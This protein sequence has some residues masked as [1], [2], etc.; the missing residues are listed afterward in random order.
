MLMLLQP[1]RTS[2][3][4]PTKGPSSRSVHCTTDRL[5]DRCLKANSQT[6][7]HAIFEGSPITCTTYLM[8]GRVPMMSTEKSQENTKCFW[9]KKSV[10]SYSSPQLAQ[11]GGAKSSRLSRIWGEGFLLPLAQKQHF[12]LC[13]LFILETLLDKLLEGLINCKDLSVFPKQ[14]GC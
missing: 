1:Q 11:C 3:P 13:A 8:E 14:S 7:V 6:V 2:S 10:K 4:S 9:K 12:V 5:K